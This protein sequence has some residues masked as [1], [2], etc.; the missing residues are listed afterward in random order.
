MR[1]LANRVGRLESNWRIGKE[2]RSVIRVILSAIAPRLNLQ[3]S[4]CTRRLSSNGDLTELVQLDGSR[5]ELSNEEL[6][7]FIERFPI[8][9]EGV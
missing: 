7:E 8:E 4:T 3:T 2:P 1:A 9:P 6:N 5:D